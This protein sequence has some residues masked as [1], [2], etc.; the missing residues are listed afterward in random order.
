MIYAYNFTFRMDRFSFGSKPF[1]NSE[2]GQELSKK[3]HTEPLDQPEDGF[4]IVRTL[5]FEESEAMNI[6]RL[7][8]RE[9]IIY[10]LILQR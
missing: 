8:D 2:E 5:K 1:E 7:V 10:T 3:K 4:D 9:G 6:L